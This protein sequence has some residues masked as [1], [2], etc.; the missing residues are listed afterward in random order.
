MSAKVLIVED[1]ADSRNYLAALLRIKGYRVDTAVDGLEGI[2]HAV[3][4]HPD[5]IISDISMPNL[6]GIQMLKA[7]RKMP[8]CKEIP[9]VAV[10]AYGSG[11]LEDA[12]AVG[13]D[14]TLRKPLNCDLLLKTID[15][16]L[17]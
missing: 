10:S 3:A 11:R 15:R 16:L 9:V 8:R 1:N 17:G 12:A 7:L 5:L 13:A 4:D 6:D 14:S 2:R